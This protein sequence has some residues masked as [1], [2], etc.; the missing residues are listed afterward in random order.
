MLT[1]IGLKFLF[2]DQPY[3]IIN[4]NSFGMSPYSQPRWMS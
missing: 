2:V 3:V 1:K 4:S